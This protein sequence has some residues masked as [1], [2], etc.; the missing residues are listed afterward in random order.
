MAKDVAPALLTSGPVSGS[1][2]A[3]SLPILASSVLQSLNASINAVWIGQV[4]GERALSASTNV[5]TLL[6]LFVLASMGFGF[7][8]SVLIGQA[9]G[10]GNMLLVRRTFVTSVVFLAILSIGLAVAG[11]LGARSILVALQTPPDA[12]DLATS[13]LRAIFPALPAMY[14]FN[15]VMLAL[16][17]AGDS[18][19]PFLCLMLTVVLD[20]ALNP[21][22]MRGFGPVPP[23][24]IA[25]SA[26]ATLIATATSLVVMVVR[27]YATEHFLRLT[28]SDLRFLRGGGELLLALVVK[29]TPM[30]L[31]MLVQSSSMLVMLSLVNR[32]G[33]QTTAAYGACFQLWNYVQMPGMALA[34]AVSS[35]AAQNIGARR[36]DRVTL[37]TRVG[38][39]MSVALTT[40]LSLAIWGMSEAAL[41]LVLRDDREA[42]DAGRHILVIATWSFVPVAISQVQSGV[43][44]AAGA[45]MAPFVLLVLALWGVRLPFAYAFASRWGADALWW[46]F[47]A[48]A[49]AAVVLTTLYYR[50]GRWREARLLGTERI[51]E[52]VP[53]AP[54]AVA[55]I[56]SDNAGH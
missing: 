23:L 41:G 52:A 26:Y 48:G 6:F 56:A 28:A 24:G 21:L 33:S 40:G 11:L 44:R 13:Y 29:G 25:G 50:L 45:V 55:P 51:G 14:L 3:F 20:V 7:A 16:R 10:A 1:L 36:W 43:M 2:I 53:S 39:V 9:I 31:N 19:T 17:G 37:I 5:T 49:G 34:A 22:L 15:L 8:S 12:L 30:S 18:K 42:M 27:L 32:F 46:S 47:P 35:M 38:M 4:L 54:V